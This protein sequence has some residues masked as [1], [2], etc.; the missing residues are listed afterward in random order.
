MQW[1]VDTTDVITTTGKTIGTGVGCRGGGDGGET[2]RG[3]RLQ[4]LPKRGWD[5]TVVARTRCRPRRCYRR[6]AAV[7][8]RIDEL[9]YIALH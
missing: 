8:H 1:E 2:M 6:S 5:V 4:Y 3:R 9:P 7:G